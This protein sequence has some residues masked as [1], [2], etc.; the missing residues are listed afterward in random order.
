M[1]N[2]KMETVDRKME[3]INFCECCN[4]QEKYKKT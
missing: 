1:D 2:E 4:Y 3:K